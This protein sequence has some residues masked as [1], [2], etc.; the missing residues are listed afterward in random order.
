M[1]N[2]HEEKTDWIANLLNLFLISVETKVLRRNV[3]D[4]NFNRNDKKHNYNGINEQMYSDSARKYI[5]MFVE[6]LL[7]ELC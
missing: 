5:G 1:Q 7:L 2:V 6:V 3:K 4:R